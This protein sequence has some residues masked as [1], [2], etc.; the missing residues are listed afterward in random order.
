MSLFGPQAIAEAVSFKVAKVS[1]ELL[2]GH[3]NWRHPRSVA[4]RELQRVCCQ[5]MLRDRDK[6]MWSASTNGCFSCSSA[7]EVLRSRS[8]K[9]A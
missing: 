9:V 6:E 3:W 4:V 7:W 1:S 8:D 5:V 2:D